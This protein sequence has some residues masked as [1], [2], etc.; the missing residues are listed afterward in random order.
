MFFGYSSYFYYVTIAL[1]AICVYHCV[2]KGNQ[3]SWIWLIVCLPI[4]GC[5]IYFFTE[6]FSRRSVGNVQSSIGSMVNPSGR[7]SKLQENL[8]F[9]DTFNNRIALADAYLAAGDT[10]K[11]IAIYEPSLT[12]A[13]DENEHVLMQLIIAYS[14]LQRYADVVKAAQKLKN[15]PQFLR[16]RAH[17]L[18]AMALAYMGNNDAAEKEFKVLN[19]KFSGFES[20]YHYGLFLANNNR[21]NEA[22]TV[23][24]DMLQE[25]PHL[26]G[27]EKRGNRN[28]F[29]LTKEEL[30]KMGN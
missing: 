15:K 17:M 4:I 23:Y 16:S 29:A 26:S 9:S 24:T 13:F 21:I 6:I 30:R 20:R 19:S 22:R 27:R 11:A 18:Y 28:W 25:E 5:A 12:G 1:Q 14:R 7:I 8:K 2:K 10:E 3:N